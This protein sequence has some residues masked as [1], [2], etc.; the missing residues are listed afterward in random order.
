MLPLLETIVISPCGT[1]IDCLNWRK[2]PTESQGSSTVNVS[3]NRSVIILSFVTINV[4]TLLMYSFC[5]VVFLVAQEVI[6]N[7]I[8]INIV[9]LVIIYFIAYMIGCIV[10]LT[11]KENV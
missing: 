6:A 9:F 7:R 10:R 8:T 1:E 2:F 4:S 5:I 3:V 11:R